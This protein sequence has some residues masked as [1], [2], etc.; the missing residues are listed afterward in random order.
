MSAIFGII[1]KNAGPISIP[2]KALMKE[3]LMHHAPDGRSY[4]ESEDCFL[5]HHRQITNNHQ[6]NDTLP[7]RSES[8]IITSYANISNRIPLA[9]LLGLPADRDTISDP[10][11]I[12]EA[13][14]KWGKDCVK[15]FEGEFA[16]AIWNETDHT[17]FAAC[18][19][20]GLRSFYYYDSPELFVFS[21]EIKAVLAAKPLPHLFDEYEIIAGV[22][23]QFTERTFVKEV[24]LWQAGHTLILPKDGIIRKEKYWQLEPQR[25][26]AFKTNAEWGECLRELLNNFLCDK[27]DTNGQAGVMLSGGLDSS[28]VAAVAGDILRK[29]NK[30][31]YAFSGRLPD[32]SYSKGRDERYYQDLVAKHI[33]NLEMVHIQPEPGTGPLSNLNVTAYQFE[34]IPNLFHYLD[35]EIYTAA[36]DRKISVLLNGFM[37]D[38]AVSKRRHDALYQLILKGEIKTAA[39]LFRQLKKKQGQSLPSLLKSDIFQHLPVWKKLRALRDRAGEKGKSRGFSDAIELRITEALLN[40]APYNKE[41]DSIPFY[42]NKGTL[43]HIMNYYDKRAPWFG[44]EQGSPFVSKTILEFCMDV[45]DEVFLSRGFRRGLIREAMEGLLPPEIQWR[46]DKTMYTPDFFERVNTQRP[47]IEEILNDAAYAPYLHFANK[48][49]IIRVLEELKNK[50]TQHDPVAPI[51]VFSVVSACVMKHFSEKLGLIC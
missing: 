9:G 47:I 31:L 25:R 28:F 32:A 26:Y 46:K 43:G 1:N 51:A 50:Q 22:T 14:R 45:P 12:I 2:V 48:G 23:K 36:R 44:F 16:F 15:Y 38:M 18:D 7:L 40:A 4:Y 34:A 8:L 13:Y 6:R 39:R 42:V 37:G 35:T 17:L 3:S 5:G 21:S 24:K 41:M 27:L 29:Q 10:K 30:T 11:L 20:V 33:P 49:E 19:H